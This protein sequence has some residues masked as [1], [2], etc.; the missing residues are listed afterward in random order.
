MGMPFSNAKRAALSTDAAVT[1]PRG[2][3]GS[4]KRG[5]VFDWL[6]KDY[7]KYFVGGRATFASNWHPTAGETGAILDSSFAFIPTLI[8]DRG[9]RNDKWLAT[10]KGLI[11]GGVKTIFAYVVP[12]CEFRPIARGRDVD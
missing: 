11:Q 1:V 12:Q 4:G 10:V 9:L 8:V 7:S 2:L 6:S 3:G 5:L